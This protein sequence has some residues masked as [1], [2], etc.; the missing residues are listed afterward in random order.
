MLD[1]A[2]AGY[3]WRR[4]VTT[5]TEAVQAVTDLR[6]AGVDFIKVHDHTPRDVYFAIAAEAGR[7]GL[8][9]AGHVPATVTVAEAVEAGQASIEHFA[10]FRVFQECRQTSCPALYDSL[11]SRGVWQ[12]PTVAYYQAVPSM[13]RGETATPPE[14]VSPGL[15]ALWRANTQATAPDERML[16]ALADINVR[17]LNAIPEM[18]RHNVGFLAGCDALVPGF[19]L[20]DELEWFTRAGLT[21]AEAL[22]TAT[23]NPARYL[24]REAGQGSVAEGRAADLV[25]LDANPLEDIR[26]TRRISA[27]ILR[28]RLFDR[29]ALDQLLAQSRAAFA[30]ASATPEPQGETAPRSDAQPGHAH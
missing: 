26:N 6:T 3:P 2:P 1:D 18:L 8:P 16:A 15:A 4:R 25:L 22:R 12:T 30:S 17:T 29:A 5:P 7:Q 19:C 13:L 27:V 21:P 9:F 11:A 24:G 23:I 28:G 20:H 14:Y 10:N